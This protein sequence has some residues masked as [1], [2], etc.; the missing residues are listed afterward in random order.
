MFEP[1]YE[2]VWF[3]SFYAF[4]ILSYTFLGV[5]QMYLIVSDLSK[6]DKDHLIDQKAPKADNRV[7]V[8]DHDQRYGDKRR[9]EDNSDDRKL[10]ARCRRSMS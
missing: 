10:R 7:I 6:R 8:L 4:I 1:L 5:Y 2:S 3:Q 9:R